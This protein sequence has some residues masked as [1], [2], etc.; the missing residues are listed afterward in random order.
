MHVKMRA[1]FVMQTPSALAQLPEVIVAS[2]TLG[3]RVTVTAA[4][5][6]TI[7]NMMN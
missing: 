4:L 3:S 1:Q 5:P 6:V 2:A 7:A